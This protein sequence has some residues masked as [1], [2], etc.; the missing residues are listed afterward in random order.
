VEDATGMFKITQDEL[1]LNNI[2]TGISDSVLNV[3]GTFREFPADIRK[4]ELSLQG[5]I[6]PGATSWVSRLIDL[7]TEMQLRPPLTVTDAAVSWEKDSKTKFDGKLAFGTGI[8]VSLRL[9]K[10]PDALTVHGI[11]IKDR[12]DENFII[13]TAQIKAGE[14]ELTLTGS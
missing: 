2:R 3:S 14:Q 1:S 9:T 7:P 6:G 11:S 12:D 8:E 13:K 4:I 5:D 10:T